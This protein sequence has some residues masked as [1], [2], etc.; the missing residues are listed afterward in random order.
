M[1]H[2]N[3]AAIKTAAPHRDSIF[4]FHHL[5]NRSSLSASADM[6]QTITFSAISHYNT[7]NAT[8]SFLSVESELH[9]QKDFPQRPLALQI[10]GNKTTNSPQQ[11][12]VPLTLSSSSFLLNNLQ[13]RPRRAK[14]ILFP[15]L[16]SL[17]TVDPHFHGSIFLLQNKSIFFRY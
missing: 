14:Q 7:D 13:F 15:Y 17:L 1:C 8:P 12:A 4:Y 16:K 6:L 11:E 3:G 5:S 2:K 9:F 10:P